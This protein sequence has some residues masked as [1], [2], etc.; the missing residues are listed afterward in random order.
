MQ[1]QNEFWAGV[2]TAVASPVAVAAGIA[3]GSYDAATGN[4]AFGD[5]FNAAAE[6]IIGAAKRFGGEHGEILTRGV[7]T[8]AATTLGGHFV[9]EGLKRLSRL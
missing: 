1:S 4:G 2:V 3:K 5:G 7:L 8:G 9:R 6:P